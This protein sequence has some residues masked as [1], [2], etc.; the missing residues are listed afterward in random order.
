MKRWAVNNPELRRART[1]AAQAK[2]HAAKLLRTP[3]WADFKAISEFYE[4]C[5]PGMEV[6]HIVPLQGKN[7]SGLHV[8]EN[9][10]YL[11]EED[12]RSK[13]NTFVL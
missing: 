6:D 3:P 1:R 13:S 8:R 11:S 5:P 9:L 10:Q 2:R 7:V 12:N 4:A